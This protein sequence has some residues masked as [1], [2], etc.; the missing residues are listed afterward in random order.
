M[1]NAH[2]GRIVKIS[3][4]GLVVFAA[5]ALGLRSA[6]G[7]AAQKHPSLEPPA[8]AA[9]IASQRD[10][11]AVA[12]SQVTSRLFHAELD[13]RG[14]SA[15]WPLDPLWSEATSELRFTFVHAL[16]DRNGF[17]SALYTAR[18]MSG[19]SP[20]TLWRLDL[21][22]EGR[23][24]WGDFLWLFGDVNVRTIST[25]SASAR[26]ASSL[27]I[28]PR[29]AGSPLPCLVFGIVSAAGDGYLALG[30]NC[31]GTAGTTSA[32]PVA[33]A[34]IDKA[35]TLRPGFWSFGDIG[36][37]TDASGSVAPPRAFDLRSLSAQDA[38]TLQ[39]YEAGLSAQSVIGAGLSG[40]AQ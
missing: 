30:L 26:V 5:L 4:A 32:P 7:D 12:A 34:T 27:A 35:G 22:P 11:D 24:I 1:L 29:E 19:D 9:F 38:S 23:V 15:S 37:A 3:V 28:A 8:A 13:R 20:V 25:A 17:T 21:D 18:P 2:L 6:L 31:G 33:F 10:Q 40:T 36:P 14:L 16:A 39:T